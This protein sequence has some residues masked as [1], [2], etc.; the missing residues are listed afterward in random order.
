MRLSPGFTLTAVLTLAIGIGATTAI[1]TLVNAIMLKSLPVSDPAGLYRIGDTNECCSVGWGDDDWSIFSLPLVQRFAEAAPEFEEVTAF[2]A[3]PQMYG[4][5]SSLRDQQSRPMHVEYVQGNYFHLFGIG[6]FAGRTLLPADDNASAAPAI[7]MSYRTW[8]QAYG[9]DPSLIGSTFMMEGHLVTLVGVA[10]PGFYGDTLRSDPPDFWIPINQE[11]LIDGPDGNIHNNQAQWLYAI[12]RLKPGASVR[13]LDARLTSVLQRWARYEDQILAD[14]Q[15]Q[16]APSIPQKFIKLAP[17]GSGVATMQASYGASLRIL[18]LVCAAVLLIACAN[19]ANLLLARGTARRSQTAMRM[20]LGA[21]RTR[22]VRQ[23]LTEAVTLAVTG[24]LFGLAIAY[25]GARLII[26]LAFHSA[27]FTPVSATPSWPVLGFGFALS[28]LTGI[29]F[30]VVPAWF[31][32]HSD[33]AEALRG[34]NR[35][36]KD[37]STLPQKLL[38]VGQ[39]AISLALLACAGLLTMSLRNLQHQDFG[40]HPEDRIIVSMNPPAAS[41]TQEHLSALTHELQDRLKQLPG[42]EN[43]SL[44]LYTPMSGNNWGELIA[45]PGKSDPAPSLENAASLNRVTSNYLTTIGQPIVRGRN[46][47]PSDAN[48]HPIAI[49]DQAFAERFFP[50]E[51]PIGKHFGTDAARYSSTFEVVG[52]AANAKY[53][54]GGNPSFPMFYLPFDQ[55]EH[56]NDAETQSIEKMSHF[57]SNIQILVHG[58]PQSLEPQIRRAI[59]EIDPSLTVVSVL[60]MQQQVDS[61]FDQARMVAN[62]A[63]AFGLIALLLA[64]IG[65]YGL[66]AYNVARRTAEIGLRMALGADR[67]MIVRMVMRGA[68]IQVAIGLAIGLPIAIIGGHLMASQLFHVRSWDPLVLGGSTLVLAAC[69]ALA[70]ILPARRAASTQPMKALRTD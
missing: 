15:A 27:T 22:L 14:F 50:G 46:F 52:V 23:Q 62:L 68:F 43:V 29:I 37:Q 63:G 57:L 60:S 41:S 20:A 34:V 54:G 42:V 40:F 17:A 7:M 26:S 6:A 48:G 53:N 35:T 55:H 69:A 5:R 33:P 39:A 56:Y 16:V 12:G 10:P 9:S 8:Q 2:S 21:G 59:G 31:T 47:Q 11:L 30:G 64:T 65:L 32:R 45:V 13:G 4:V 67:L 25:L 24:G 38:V 66:T 70:S 44:A 36:T 28:L 49:V 3:S 51:N 18:L 61:N 19:I 1:F 58:G